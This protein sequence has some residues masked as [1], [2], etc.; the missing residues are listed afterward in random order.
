MPKSAAANRS[1]PWAPL[2]AG[3]EASAAVCRHPLRCRD[4]RARER[5]C[6]HQLTLGSAA[7]AIGDVARPPQAEALKTTPREGLNPLVFTE[8]SVYSADGM[9]RSVC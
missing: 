4:T 9:I 7:E 3:L 8:R 1:G 5:Y 2:R 6:R